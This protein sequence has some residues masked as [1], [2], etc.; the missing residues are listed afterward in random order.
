MTT[1][2]SIRLQ[3]VEDCDRDEPKQLYV[4]VTERDGNGHEEG[5][6]WIPVELLP[7]LICDLQTLTSNPTEQAA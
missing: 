3:Q 6:I 4:I 2:F 7:N 1:Q 5:D